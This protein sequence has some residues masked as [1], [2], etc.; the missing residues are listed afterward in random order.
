M[1]VSKTKPCMSKYTISDFISTT[2]QTPR[3]DNKDGVTGDY[4]VEIKDQSMDDNGNPQLD[5]DDF[6]WG[7]IDYGFQLSKEEAAEILK[8]FDRDN[9]G[10]IDFNE[11]L[12]FLKVSN[13]YFS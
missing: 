4:L 9:S 3:L 8:K 10:T 13:S 11:F 1:I 6:R 5:V 12:R 7:F 2:I